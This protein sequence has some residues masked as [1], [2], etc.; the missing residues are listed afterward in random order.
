M[1][2]EICGRN[3]CTKSFHALDEQNNFDEI[4]DQIKDNMKAQLI[5]QI[6]KLE[7]CGTHDTKVLVDVSEVIDII[8]SYS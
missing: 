4:A 3:N 7:D 1:A 2:C 8:N 6:N 5:R